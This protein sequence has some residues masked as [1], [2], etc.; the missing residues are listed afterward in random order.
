MVDKRETQTRKKKGQ[1]LPQAPKQRGH[2]RRKDLGRYC[3][4]KDG[5]VTIISPKTRRNLPP[6]IR[7]A[8]NDGQWPPTRSLRN[9]PFYTED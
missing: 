1:D 9:R 2:C 8:L 4:N 3:V 7:S 6:G 5:I